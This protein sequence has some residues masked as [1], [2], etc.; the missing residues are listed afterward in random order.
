MRRNGSRTSDTISINNFSIPL[1]LPTNGENSCVAEN[2]PNDNHL[3]LTDKNGDQVVEDHTISQVEP[4]NEYEKIIENRFI[5][6]LEEIEKT[7]R[8]PPRNEEEI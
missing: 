5:D 3:V 7:C 2:D 4:S 6:S 1:N 8:V